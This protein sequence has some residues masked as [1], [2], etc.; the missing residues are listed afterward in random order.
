METRV[1]PRHQQAARVR[2]WALRLFL[3]LI[4]LNAVIAIAAIAGVGSGEDEQWQVLA[5]SSVISAASLVVASNAA[6]V[7]RH[8][9]GPVPWVAATAAVLGAAMIVT[10]IWVID[11]HDAERYWRTVG[12]IC[13]V[14]VTG[15][16]MSLVA[17]PALRTPWDRVQWVAHVAALAI[18]GQIVTSIIRDDAGSVRAYGISTVIFAAATIVV[19]V[20]A[21]VANAEDEPG[22]I[23]GVAASHC[24]VCGATVDAGPVTRCDRCGAHCH[25]D[26]LRAPNGNA[27]APA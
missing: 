20:G 19:L 1:E 6:A 13:T 16:A 21:R 26:V 12:V 25:V 22:P 24:P 9:L 8:R 17:M 18:G 10:G 2:A 3:V 23:A 14:A 27:A 11:L 4:A 7:A 5:T 15:T